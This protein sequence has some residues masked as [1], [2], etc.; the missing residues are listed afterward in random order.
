MARSL[1]ININDRRP[2]LTSTLHDF[3]KDGT[4]LIAIDPAKDNL[5]VGVRVS[6]TMKRY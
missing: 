1:E 4:S 2:A 6:V 3:L 5:L